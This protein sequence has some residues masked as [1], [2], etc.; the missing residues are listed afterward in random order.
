MTIIGPRPVEAWN[1]F[2]VGIN[3]IKIQQI[4]KMMISLSALYYTNMLNL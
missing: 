2:I 1:N 4:N 3:S